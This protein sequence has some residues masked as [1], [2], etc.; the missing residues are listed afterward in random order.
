MLLRSRTSLTDNLAAF[1][2]VTKACDGWRQ[3]RERQTFH[4]RPFIFVS[5]LHLIIA[6]SLHPPLGA[7]TH[8]C[9]KTTNF[10]SR[11]HKLLIMKGSLSSLTPT[12]HI[13]VAVCQF[14]VLSRLPI[15]RPLSDTWTQ[16]IILE[17]RQNERGGVSTHQPNDFFYLTVYSGADQRKHQS[18]ASLA[19]VREFTIDRWI[20]RTKG[21]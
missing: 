3:N 21:K 19:F 18:S 16:A 9:L 7:S 1:A 14:A 8:A 13:T 2:H 12:D 10:V 11:T 5:A 17:W 6:P 15:M 4:G 20:P